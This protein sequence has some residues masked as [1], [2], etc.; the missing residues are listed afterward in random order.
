LRGTDKR[1][2]RQTDAS[3]IDK[4]GHSEQGAVLTSGKIFLKYFTQRV[5]AGLF[6]QRT[7]FANFVQDFF[8]KTESRV[9]GVDIQ[10]E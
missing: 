1:T 10:G 5:T 4:T 2:D 9:S 6:A 8:K 7:R 3:A